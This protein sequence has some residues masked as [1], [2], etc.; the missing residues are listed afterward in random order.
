MAEIK[1]EASG[2]TSVYHPV[3]RRDSWRAVMGMVEMRS[4]PFVRF[5]DARTGVDVLLNP[6]ACSI[7]EFVAGPEEQPEEPEEVTE[8]E[9]D[10]GAEG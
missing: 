5:L 6:C 10:A 4:M 1:V 7:I 9:A 3:I 8:V 2:R